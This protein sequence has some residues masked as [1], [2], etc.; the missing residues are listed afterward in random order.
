M[1]PETKLKIG[2]T[3]I[4]ARDL[5]HDERVAF[6]EFA[7]H[8]A[9]PRIAELLAGEIERS[10]EPKTKEHDNLLFDMPPTL[11][12]KE[13]AEYLRVSPSRI[14]EMCRIH[15]GKFFP[16]FKVGKSIKVPRDKFIGWINNGGLVRIAELEKELKVTKKRIAD[17]ELTIDIFKKATAIF[18]Q[19]NRK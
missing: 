4:D 12:V 1:K 19:D 13:A 2:D 3:V 7:I 15:H 8:L 9:A 11:T 6:I 14:Y 5:D 18:V 10:E 16:H 17:Q